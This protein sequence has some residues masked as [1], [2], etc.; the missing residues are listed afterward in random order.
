MKTYVWHKRNMACHQKNTTTMV[1]HGV[2]GVSFGA[3]FLYNELNQGGGNNEE[4]QAISI[5]KLN[6]SAEKK[7]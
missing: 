4:L 2:D 1:K 5:Q 6:A 7:N 3:D